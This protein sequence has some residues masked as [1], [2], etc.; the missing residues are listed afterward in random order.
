VLVPDT[1]EQHEARLRGAG[2]HAVRQ[3]FQC[4]NFV[5]FMAVK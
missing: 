4:L 1:R 2:F 5:S 3:W